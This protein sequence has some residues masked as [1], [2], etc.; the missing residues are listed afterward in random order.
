MIH[1][2][3]VT[4]YKFEIDV[5]MTFLIDRILVAK[6]TVLKC[7]QVTSSRRYLE[8]Q[9]FFQGGKR[10]WNCMNVYKQLKI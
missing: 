3:P 6:N 1:H 9:E 8:S 4:G 10:F 2:G 7:F 5:Y